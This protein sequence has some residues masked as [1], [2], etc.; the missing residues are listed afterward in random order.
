MGDSAADLGPT[1]TGGL[2]AGGSPG[3]KGSEEKKGKTVECPRNAPKLAQVCRVL[4]PGGGTARIFMVPIRLF[5]DPLARKLVALKAIAVYHPDLG[6]QNGSPGFIGVR[7][8]ILCTCVSG[9]A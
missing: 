5:C 3:R 2:R 6:G 4:L 7:A 1:V 9:C 8:F